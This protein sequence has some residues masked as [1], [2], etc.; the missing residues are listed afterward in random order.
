MDC[1]WIVRVTVSVLDLGWNVGVLIFY[2]CGIPCIIGAGSDEFTIEVHHGG[3]F[4]LE[5]GS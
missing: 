2:S 4:L 1:L 3:F 5:V